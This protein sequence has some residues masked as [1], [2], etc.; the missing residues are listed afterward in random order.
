MVVLDSDVM[1]DIIR[2]YAPA[3]AWLDSI[4]SEEILLPGFVALELYQ[5]CRNRS[6]QS[7]V[8]DVLHQIEIV[9]P[10]SETCDLALEQYKRY[11]LSNNLSII[12]ALIG[13]T[14]ASLGLTLYT[15]SEKH[16]AVFA[17]LTTVR[18]YS[19]T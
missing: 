10:E 17:D 12:D 13:Q 15:F 7:D 9:W 4:A 19:K 16:Y 14:A 18:P 2:D 3:L 1:I 6:E 8:D 5:G 11:H